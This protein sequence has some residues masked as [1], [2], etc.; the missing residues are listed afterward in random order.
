[1]L[2][3]GCGQLAEFARSSFG[4][5]ATTYLARARA[6]TYGLV[7]MQTPRTGSQCG[8]LAKDSASDFFSKLRTGRTISF[9]LVAWWNSLSH[10]LSAYLNRA[11]CK[12][13]LPPLLASFNR[14]RWHHRRRLRRNSWPG[15]KRSTRPHRRLH[16]VRRLLATNRQCP[17]PAPALVGVV[18]YL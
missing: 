7:Y 3:T 8:L 11:Q 13:F 6:T 16:L 4:S 10:S 5:Q 9:P 15:C 14:Q 2:N 17:A 12:R 1:M 18:H